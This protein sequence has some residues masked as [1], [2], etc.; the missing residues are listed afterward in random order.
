MS[1]AE[2]LKTVRY[3]TPDA[4]LCSPAGRLKI[5][6]LQLVARLLP[7]CFAVWLSLLDDGQLERQVRIKFGLRS[8][9]PGGSGY[10]VPR[11]HLIVERRDWL[12]LQEDALQAIEHSPDTSP[13]PQEQRK[14]GL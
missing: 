11:L 1:K 5:A 6:L 13:S 14:S 3:L 8:L 7:G 9:F 10:D 12:A 2:T 4:V